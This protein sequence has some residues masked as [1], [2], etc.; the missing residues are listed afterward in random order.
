MQV[1]GRARHGRSFL[2][3]QN[4]E[5]A[6]GGPLRQSAV[7]MYNSMLLSM[8]ASVATC[9]ARRLRRPRVAPCSKVRA[10]KW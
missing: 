7:S 5:S 1:A 3:F 10:S 8:D 2:A 9:L 4:N 6:I